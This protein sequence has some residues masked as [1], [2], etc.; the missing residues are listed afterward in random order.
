[1]EGFEGEGV[2]KGERGRMGGWSYRC[3]GQKKRERESH[4]SS[5]SEVEG[6]SHL[7]VINVHVVIVRVHRLLHERL[8]YLHAIDLDVVVVL[9]EGVVALAVAAAGALRDV[10]VAGAIDVAGDVDPAGEWEGGGGWRARGKTPN[11]S[12]TVRN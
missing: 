5:G 2:A 6:P 7:R 3:H 1:M 8:V 11:R 10:A 9:D 12:Q 4:A